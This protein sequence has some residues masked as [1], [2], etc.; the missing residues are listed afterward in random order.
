MTSKQKFWLSYSQPSPLPSQS[1]FP[2]NKA[3]LIYVGDILD[4]KDVIS[5]SSTYQLLRLATAFLFD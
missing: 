3:A 5:T 4:P 2:K 1:G